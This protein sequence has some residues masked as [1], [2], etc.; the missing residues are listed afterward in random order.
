MRATTSMTKKLRFISA[1]ET[2]STLLTLAESFFWIEAADI[3]IELRNATS[4]MAVCFGARFKPATKG[5]VF[6]AELVHEATN[7]FWF[8]FQDGGWD[9][10]SRP[11]E[12]V[13]H[14]TVHIQPTVSEAAEAE[15]V[16]FGNDGFGPTDS[17]C[18]RNHRVYPDNDVRF[19][20]T[21]LA[22][23]SY[24]LKPIISWLDIGFED[25]TPEP[26]RRSVKDKLILH[27]QHRFFPG[28]CWHALRDKNCGGDIASF[29]WIDPVIIESNIAS[30]SNPELDTHNEP[31]FLQPKLVK[32]IGTE[33]TSERLDVR[34]MRILEL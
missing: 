9:W 28:G 23:V 17:F 4:L 25:R 31:R 3:K 11:S 21:G 30:F 7:E 19:R 15:L 32:N 2:S 10:E 5:F 8:G 1:T 18:R 22:E 12:T 16:S 33:K 27:G 34:E 6:L 14:M 20:E 29:D 13:F 26:R 24:F